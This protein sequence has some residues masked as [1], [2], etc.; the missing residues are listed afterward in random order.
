MEEIKNE[1]DVCQSTDFVEQE[2]QEPA[3]SPKQIKAQKNAD[4]KK[5]KQLNKE[6]KAQ[7]KKAKAEQKARLK[8]EQ[9]DKKKQEKKDRQ[10]KKFEQQM[11]KHYRD[12]AKIEQRKSRLETDNVSGEKSSKDQ[13][14][15]IQVEPICQSVGEIAQE[16]E[17]SSKKKTSKEKKV[18]PEKK[19]AK[20]SNKT[21]SEYVEFYE[22]LTQEDKREVDEFF[23]SLDAH[24]G[25]SKQENA[26]LKE[27]FASALVYLVQSGVS[28]ED[29]LERIDS[30]Y[31]GGFYARPPVLWFALDDAAKIYPVSMDHGTMAV[32]R[33]AANMKEP[34]VPQ[35][36]QMALNFTIKR[37]PSFATT[38]KKGIFWHYLD[39]TKRRFCVEKERFMPCQPLKVSL[40][41]SQS[42]RLMYFDKR[43]SVEFF[44]VITDGRGGMT[45]FKA[46]VVEYLRLC[47]IKGE[48]DDS[49]WDVNEAPK[50][51]EFDN[52]FAKVEKPKHNSGLINK[53][54]LQMTGKLTKNKP[55]RV[56]HFK[57]SVQKMKEVAKKYSTSLTVLLLAFMF[58]ASNHAIEDIHGDVSI[59]LPVDMRKYYPS[60]TVRNFA[61]Y[62]SIRIPVEK[63][64]DVESVI[65][66]VSKQLE[67]KVTKE[68]MSE[69][70]HSTEKLVNGIR[71]IPLVIKTPIAHL[72]YGFLGDKTFTNTLSNL[73]VVKLPPAYQNE[74]EDFDF[75][76]GT[77]VTNRAGCG[78]VSYLD[79]IS[80]S[81]SKFTVDPSFEES[82]FDLL[83]SEGIATRV[84]GTVLYEG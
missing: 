7:E 47:G 56:L 48:L 58:I 41:G 45:F 24:C 36:L 42:F 49:V 63:M 81:I 68:K 80:F 28:L 57:M 53:N 1:Q 4:K 60:D 74:V 21:H 2:S 70:L 55:C 13:E 54:A 33:L 52:M 38:I 34:I 84:E 66:E 27:D 39:T 61:M 26:K 8:K 18:K 64:T 14:K 72:I 40:S 15:E 30:K 11:E 19:K 76:L 50:T 20:K 78:V 23:L 67:E 9:E 37:F 6:K 46:L 29:A 16:S 73:G 79:T 22:G 25:L 31:L 83:E 62:C 32:F 59:Q 3:L 51:E 10:I 71:L 5:Q 17:Q 75:V 44:H 43:I 82:L 12:L 69:M 65:Q 35:L 77:A